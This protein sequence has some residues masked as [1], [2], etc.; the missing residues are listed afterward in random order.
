MLETFHGHLL[1]AESVRTE[2][3][4]WYAASPGA[5]AVCL[6]FFLQ[7]G[8]VLVSITGVAWPAAERW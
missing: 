4:T 6:D 1:T 5:R 7:G 8:A 3:S 2:A